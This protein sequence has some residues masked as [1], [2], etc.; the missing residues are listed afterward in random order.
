MAQSHA[1]WEGLLLEAGYQFV[2]WDELN[3]FYVANEASE[4]ARRFPAD[5]APWNAAT[6]LYELGR[7][8]DQP[9]HPDR[10]LA[11]RL[12]RGFLASLTEFSPEFLRQLLERSAGADGIERGPELRALLRGATVLPP[13]RASIVPEEPLPLD[14]AAR[15]ALG[16][17]AAA[18]DGGLILDS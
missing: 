12:V 2:F 7:V 8:L 13:R 5:P 3:R 15:A 1:E 9:G 14:D 11:D 6:H 17:I 18:Y 10:Q 4:L 16:R